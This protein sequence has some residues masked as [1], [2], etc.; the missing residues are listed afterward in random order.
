MLH[1]ARECG[2]VC[3]RG[4]RR[5]SVPV[6]TSRGG[7]RRQEG[8][9]A[10]GLPAARPQSERGNRVVQVRARKVETW[11]DRALIS[12]DGSPAPGTGVV[13]SPPRRGGA[14]GD[15]TGSAPSACPRSRNAALRSPP[16]SL[17]VLKFPVTTAASERPLRRRS[18]AENALTFL[19]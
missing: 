4:G 7:R 13:V 14:G 6:V 2:G 19:E 15:P 9:P 1:K 17:R 3:P 12:R 10:P 16:S 18:S 5:H 8:A 11:V